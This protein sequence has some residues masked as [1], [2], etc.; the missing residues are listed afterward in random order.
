MNAPQVPTATERHHEAARRLI[1]AEQDREPCAPIRD[2][3]PGATIDDAYVIQS[4]VRE[5]TG[6]GR[7][8]FGRKIGLTSPAVQRQMGVAQPDFGTL[9]ADMAYGDNEPVP[10]SRLLQPR[11]EAEVAF[12]L[13]RDL[14][15]APV[16]TTDVIRATDFVVAAIEIVDSRIRDWDISIVDTVADNASS[17][18]LVLGGRPR[19]LHD[20]DDL[21]R[22]EMSLASDGAVVSSGVG[23]A[24]LG[25]PINAVVWLANALAA[26]GAPL[27]EGELILSGAL[28]PLVPA[29][30]DRR[31]EAAIQGL[32]SVTAHIV[33]L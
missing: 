7:R 19:R 17:G 26:R 33:P 31:Y 8:H 16:T 6:A 9:Y 11:I 14:P 23:S 5:A 12:V 21:A 25:H 1:A 10:A 22:V 20:M 32:G 27:R 28:G 18:L 15:D 4:L 24:C 29:Q 3:V 2:V 30:A 13:G